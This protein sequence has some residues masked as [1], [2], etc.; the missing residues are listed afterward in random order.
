MLRQWESVPGVISSMTV[1][2]VSPTL[3]IVTTKIGPWANLSAGCLYGCVA[4]I[5]NRWQ[6]TEFNLKSRYHSH[7]SMTMLGKLLSGQITHSSGVFP[8]K[9]GSGNT[10]T[11]FLVTNVQSIATATKVKVSPRPISSTSGAHGIPASQTHLL[12]VNQM[13]EI[14][15][16]RN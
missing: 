10:I 8:Y 15:C 7:S 6:V 2:K 5:S 16:T 4:C 3:H 9:M 13:A 1:F 11:T 12:T 14:W